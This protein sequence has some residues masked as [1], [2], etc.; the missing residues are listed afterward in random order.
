MQFKKYQHLERYG[1]DDVAD[2]EFGE[3][4]IF[5]NLDGTNASVWLDEEGNIKAGS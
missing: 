4:L 2:I 5:P 3:V 1:T